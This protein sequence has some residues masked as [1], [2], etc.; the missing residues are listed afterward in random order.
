MAGDAGGVGDH[1]P[2]PDQAWA[3]KSAQEPEMVNQKV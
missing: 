2:P 1:H 3:Q